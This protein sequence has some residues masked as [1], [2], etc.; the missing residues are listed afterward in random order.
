[1]NNFWDITH[2]KEEKATFLKKIEKTC[3]NK[4][5]DKVFSQ[6]FYAALCNNV[7]QGENGPLFFS[8]RG[9]GAF[10]ADIRNNHFNQNEDYLD[11]YCSGMKDVFFQDDS[12]VEE[13]FFTPEISNLF[14]DLGVTVISTFEQFDNEYFKDISLC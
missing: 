12:I 6:N 4:F 8:W 10:V 7:F 5:E 14:E 9:A 11:Y 2:L 13:G 1:M 3:I